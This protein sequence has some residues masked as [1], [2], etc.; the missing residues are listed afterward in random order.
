ML[1]KTQQW[2]TNCTWNK[3][4]WTYYERIGRRVSW[5][6]HISN[7]IFL[8][9]ET[10]GRWPVLSLA[11]S[12]SH[13]QC[14]V[15]HSLFRREYIAEQKSKTKFCSCRDVNPCP[16]HWQSSMLTTPAAGE[17][18]TLSSTTTRNRKWSVIYSGFYH[19]HI[20]PIDICSFW[21]SRTL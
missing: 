18:T 19:K 5:S 21:S 4:Q 13:W 1:N 16:P 17:T 12:S 2:A 3:T 20:I 11:V 9:L 6:S 15:V 8:A 14:M 7:V 10:E